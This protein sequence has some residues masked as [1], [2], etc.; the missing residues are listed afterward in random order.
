[1]VGR[2]AQE[3]M[4]VNL[5]VAIMIFVFAMIMVYNTMTASQCDIQ[6]TK[7]ISSVNQLAVSVE[8][9]YAAG[10]GSRESVGIDFE[11]KA[12]DSLAG[13]D[14]KLSRAIN[15]PG[16]CASCSGRRNCYYIEASMGGF[17]AS[18]AYSEI[19]TNLIT[20]GQF[21]G[22][23]GWTQYKWSWSIEQAIDYNTGIDGTTGQPSPSMSVWEL[24][25]QNTC[26]GVMQDVRIDP[27]DSHTL[28]WVAKASSLWDPNALV[29]VYPCDEKPTV[30]RDVPLFE[31]LHTD[32][33]WHSYRVDISRNISGLDCISIY[34]AICD[35]WGEPYAMKAWFDDLKLVPVF[36]Q[37]G[38]AQ[39]R[40][41]VTQCIDIPV[42]AD[43]HIGVL[44]SADIPL[45]NTEDINLSIYY[46]FPTIKHA[47]LMQKDDEGNLAICDMK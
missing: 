1:M 19:E 3:Q 23:A 11:V 25:T 5:L 27:L 30:D 44:P 41:I 36:R 46:Q 40:A 7:I 42:T 15:E 37:I 16:I 43:L 34:L 20:N 24:N 35:N 45:C 26:F 12:C 14:L 9:M 18:D 31:K 39:R 22:T 4:P 6:R 17:N 13:L 10:P 28:S 29:S 21:D 8:N 47:F 38:A 32:N 2:R 33:N